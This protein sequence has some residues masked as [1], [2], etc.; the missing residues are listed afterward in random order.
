M[1][2]VQRRE[3]QEPSD[4][5]LLLSAAKAC[6]NLS[7]RV[8]A[9]GELNAEYTVQCLSFV[10][11]ARSKAIYNSLTTCLRTPSLFACRVFVQHFNN[12]AAW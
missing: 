8:L 5:S 1:F 9:G 10:Q 4:R 3:R 2:F 11:P 6:G 7:P 12:T